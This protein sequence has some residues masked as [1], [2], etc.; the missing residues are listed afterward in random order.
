MLHGQALRTR[1]LSHI[2]T[3]TESGMYNDMAVVGVDGSGEAERDS[4]GR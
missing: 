4:G 1:F 2:H 3:N